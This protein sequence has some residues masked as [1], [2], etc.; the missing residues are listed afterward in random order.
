M[1]G[2]PSWRGALDL[3]IPPILITILCGFLIVALAMADARSPSPLGVAIGGALATSG[4]AFALIGVVAFRRARTTV[5]PMHPDRSRRLVTT[6]VYAI[7]RNPM[8][9]GF[10][11]ALLGAAIALSSPLGLALAAAAALYLDRFQI[12]PEECI[13]AASFG[14]E[15]VRYQRRVRRWL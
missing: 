15:F 8:Y 7:S 10:V 1:R 5:D 11:A 6:G 9:V 2:R 14:E 4:L 12:R 3:R 13:L